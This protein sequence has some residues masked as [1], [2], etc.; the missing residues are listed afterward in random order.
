MPS[1]SSGNET[2]YIP[3]TRGIQKINRLHIFSRWAENVYSITDADPGISSIGWDGTFAGKEA[4]QGIYVVIAE[5]TLADGTT[6]TYK[7]DLLL[8][9]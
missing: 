9:R 8:M 1:S 3:Q 5:F 4:E 6:W 7:G 2:F